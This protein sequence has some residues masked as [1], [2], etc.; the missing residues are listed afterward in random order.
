VLYVVLMVNSAP[1]PGKTSA[2]AD[3]DDDR[4][5]ES[6]TAHESDTAA[7]DDWLAL[8][9]PALAEPA[10]ADTEDRRALLREI[11]FRALI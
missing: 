10:L 11:I 9:G 4:A 5:P 7:D 1:E 8:A 2:T 3:P 6:D